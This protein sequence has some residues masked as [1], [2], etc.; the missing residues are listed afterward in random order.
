MITSAQ[1]VYY[2]VADMKRSLD[3]YCRILGMTARETSDYWSSLDCGGV[4]VGL[5]WTGGDTVPGVPRDS[6]GAH[7]GA[8]LTLKCTDAERD[9]QTLE[10]S[11]ARI[12]GMSDEPWGKM[13]V[14]ED[15]DGNV[16]KLMEPKA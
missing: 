2:N 5:H 9:A 4:T 12:L 15:P 3:F 10:K 1:D 7:C 6:H 8:T 14:F 16:L 11:G 13:V